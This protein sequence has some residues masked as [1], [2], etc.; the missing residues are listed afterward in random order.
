MTTCAPLAKSPNCASQ[1][2]QR[3]RLGRGVAVLERQHRRFRQ[4][5]ID[6]DEIRLVRRDILQGDVVTLIEL[7]AVLV[8][9]HGMAMEERAA[10]A[11]LSGQADRVTFS[12]QAGIRHIFGHT[13][14]QRQFAFAHRRTVGDDLL[15]AGMQFEIFRDGRQTFRDL[16][17]TR[18]RHCRI[19]G[20]IPG[21]I[22]FVLRPADAV[23]V[24]ESGQCRLQ[25]IASLIHRAPVV[26]DHR[27][28]LVRRHRALF[29]QT[30]GV[31]RARAGMLVDVA[32]HERLGDQRLVLFV[33][34]QLAETHHVNHHVLAE[35]H[36]EVERKLGDTQHR[37]RVVPIHME[38]RRIDHLRHIGAIQRGAGVA[39]VRRGETDLVVD[40]DV[41]RAAGTE[42]ARLRQV[43]RLLIH[44]LAGKGGIAVQQHRQHLLALMILAPMLARAHRTFHHRIDDLQ[45]RRIEGQRDVHGPARRAD[46]G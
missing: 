38:D 15:D 37:L 31:Q 34:P 23:F 3:I 14:V 5:G 45:M 24:F 13:P 12:H 10:P 27:L 4:D 21:H 9:Q 16:L 36:A 19:H 7:H 32:I 17:Q 22:A 26:R 2:S 44:A 43:E 18:A 20:G 11:V 30:F 42:A 40:D 41:H 8:V 6:D 35:M 39:R 28:R 33:V 25:G 29:D 1:I 46:V